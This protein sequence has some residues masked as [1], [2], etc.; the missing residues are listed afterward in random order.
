VS[1]CGEFP[2]IILK[3]KIRHSETFP[4]VKNKRDKVEGIPCSKILICTE[5]STKQGGIKGLWIMGMF[6]KIMV[7]IKR[8][9]G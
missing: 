7:G 4:D 3:H 6:S 8:Y 5:W 1:G 9:L 2:G